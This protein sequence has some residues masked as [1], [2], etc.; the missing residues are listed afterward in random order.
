MIDAGEGIADTFSDIAGLISQCAFSNCAHRTE[1]GC[2]I[3]RALEDGTLSPER[4]EMYARLEMEN[5]WSMNRKNEQ[6]VS[7]ALR[8]REL[9]HSGKKRGY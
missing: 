9:N 8:R 4:W 7:I 6:M 1:P 3:R 2:A 5:R